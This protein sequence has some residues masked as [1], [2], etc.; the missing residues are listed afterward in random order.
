MLYGCISLGLAF[1]ISGAEG[2]VQ[3]SILVNGTVGGPLLGVF[4]L[5]M[6]FPWSNAKGA[7][8]GTLTAFI[9]SMWLGLGATYYADYIVP[10]YLDTSVEGC[11]ANMTLP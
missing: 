9:A 7:F 11:P 6:L 8:V 2:V 3:V 5:G 4:L 10:P 1:I